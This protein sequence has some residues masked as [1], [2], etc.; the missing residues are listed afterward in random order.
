MSFFI[1]GFLARWRIVFSKIKNLAAEG[2]ISL[3][4]GTMQAKFWNPLSRGT[5]HRCSILSGKFCS[6]T[7][8]TVKSGCTSGRRKVSQVVIQQRVTSNSDD[9][10]RTG[11]T[12][13]MKSTR[14]RLEICSKHVIYRTITI[15]MKIT[16]LSMH[17]HDFARNLS[18]GNH[19]SVL[20]RRDI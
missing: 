14:A 15:S 11:D 10:T 19:F 13:L 1:V 17:M 2:D 4:S 8:T 18:I 3:A 7:E 16:R 12:R 9:R 20:F 5:G 6:N